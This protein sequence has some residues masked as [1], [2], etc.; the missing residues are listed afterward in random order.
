M[1][2]LFDIGDEIEIALKGKVEQYSASKNGDCYV[3]AL[4]GVE[5]E[6]SRVY[7]D[8]AILRKVAKINK[9]QE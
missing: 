5:P 8:S 7:L 3:I 6:G 2:T 1:T 9:E 4:M